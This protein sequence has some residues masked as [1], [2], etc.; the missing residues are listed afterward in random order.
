MKK[1]LSGIAI[2]SI[3]TLV[4]STK[5]TAKDE[6]SD[7]VAAANGYAADAMDCMDEANNWMDIL[8]ND[9]AN[10]ESDAVLGADQSEIGFWQGSATYAAG[11][12]SAYA[13]QASA[14]CM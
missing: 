6:C 10:N 1:L 4:V 11:V 7:L 2:A 8:S 5:V 12:A 13:K 3:L 9:V 14:V